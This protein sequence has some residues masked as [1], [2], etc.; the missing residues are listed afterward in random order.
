LLKWSLPDQKAGSVFNPE[1]V[2]VQLGHPRYNLT[3]EVNQSYNLIYGGLP[4]PLF[5]GSKEKSCIDLLKDFL[6]PVALLEL[7]QAAQPL[8]E[9]RA[10]LRAVPSP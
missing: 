8:V 2:W 5:R 10:L 4:P 7:A 6:P 9:V 3:F 1:R